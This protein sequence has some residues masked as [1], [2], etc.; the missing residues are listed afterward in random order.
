V[1][2]AAL[3]VAVV[4]LLLAAIVTPAVAEEGLPSDPE[5][6]AG[7]NGW[8]RA[9]VCFR[10]WAQAQGVEVRWL[11]NSEEAP[12][13][14]VLRRQLTPAVEAEALPVA[15]SIGEGEFVYQDYDLAAGAL[16]QYQLVARSAESSWG[17]PLEAGLAAAAV[18]SGGNSTHRVY[19]PLALSQGGPG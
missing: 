15:C 12:E 5:S 16:Y 17:D 1:Q 7:G 2:K 18:D 11:V 6:W 10:V 13:L 3:A 19:L 8:C 9:G 14:M 4:G